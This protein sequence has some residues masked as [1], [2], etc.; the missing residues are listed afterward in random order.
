MIT[1]ALRN[2]DRQIELTIQADNLDLQ[3]MY[4]MPIKAKP[5]N[6]HKKGNC[7]RQVLYP[8]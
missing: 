2:K 4:F 7:Q 8:K 6:D 3:Y 5:Y 1:D